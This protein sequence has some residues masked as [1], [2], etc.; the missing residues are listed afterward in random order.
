MGGWEW[1]SAAY[2][3]NEG[4]NIAFYDGRVKYLP[5]QQIYNYSSL[6]GLTITQ[7]MR[8]NNQSWLPIP[9]KECIDE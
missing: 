8:L 9:G 6:G 1:D 2:R 4:A 5:K 7:A 3:H